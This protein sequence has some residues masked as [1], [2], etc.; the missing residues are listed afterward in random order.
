MWME[1]DTLTGSSLTLRW[2]SCSANLYHKPASIQLEEYVYT[3]FALFSIL[4][5]D[6]VVWKEL[7]NFV[8]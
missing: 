7:K 3:Y 5:M 8:I 1:M 4:S 2:K 6:K